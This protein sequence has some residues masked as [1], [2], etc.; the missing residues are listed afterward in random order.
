MPRHLSRIT[1]TDTDVCLQQ[2]QD[3]AETDALAESFKNV[4]AFAD[5]WNSLNKTDQWHKNL[6]VEVITFK[7]VFENI[8]KIG[9]RIEAMEQTTR[10]AG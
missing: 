10:G 2:L 4:G 3:I 8:D 1:L 7:P 9:A 6:A 5:Y